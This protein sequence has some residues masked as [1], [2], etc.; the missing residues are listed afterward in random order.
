LVEYVLKPRPGW[1]PLAVRDNPTEYN[2]DIVEYDGNVLKAIYPTTP[3]TLRMFKPKMPP[4]FYRVERVQK[5]ISLHR[6]LPEDHFA[7]NCPPH[8]Q[9]VIK[10]V[11]DR[12]E[13]TLEDIFR[14]LALDWR[15]VPK[16]ERGQKLVR[17]LVRWMY[18]PGGPAY[19][20]KVR[21]MYRTGVAPSCDPPLIE[22]HRGYDPYEWEIYELAK[23]RGMVS[24]AEIRAYIIDVLR[25]LKD[26]SYLKHV[27]D[28]MTK[29]GNLERVGELYR[30]GKNLEPFR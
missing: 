28:G 29:R 3:D 10:T 27:I 17:E 19:L 9:A 1:D 22:L 6:E 2:S 8:V 18:E 13:A 23:R 12:E 16:D 30:A 5:R 4:S 26:E 20:I 21:G 15:I 25:W 11:G 14:S 24:Y 7:C